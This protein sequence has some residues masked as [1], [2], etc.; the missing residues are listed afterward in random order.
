MR[1]ELVMCDEICNVYV[2]Y[3]FF[4]QYDYFFNK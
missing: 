2:L 4:L 1:Y 3:V